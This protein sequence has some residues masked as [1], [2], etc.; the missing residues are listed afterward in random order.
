MT[1]NDESVD[2]DPGAETAI[3][4][5]AA[6]ET[7]LMA[8]TEASSATMMAWSA[9]EAPALS[10]PHSWRLAA[11]IAAGVVVGVVLLAG[12]VGLTAWTLRPA[13]Q[14]AVSGWTTLTQMLPP[15]PPPPV[16]VTAAPPAPPAPPPTVTVE[17]APPPPR[18][19]DSVA[20]PP[21][22]GTDVF[23]ICP[24]GHE[25]VVG[26][27]TACAFAENVRQIFYATGMSNSFTAFSPVTGDGYQMTCVGR[28][29]A[30]FT[31]GSTKVSTRCYGGDNAE[32]V[33]W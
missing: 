24:D 20:L 11:G 17:A 19:S 32:V 6:D 12:A 5:P 4:P 31:D 28:Y 21:S 33:I 16:T 15:P 13:P 18:R 8:A 22:G 25:G 2:A 26:G 3:G 7:E 9:A 27:H 29:P 30:Y 1:S 23:I 10:A 14:P